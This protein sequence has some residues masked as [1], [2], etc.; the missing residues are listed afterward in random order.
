MVSLE[1]DN[2]LV[3][4]YLSA[5]EIWPNN[6]GGLLWKEAYKRGDYCTRFHPNLNGIL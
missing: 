6:R 1:G 4:Y 3:F 2:L 5:C